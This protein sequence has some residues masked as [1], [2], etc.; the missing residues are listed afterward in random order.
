MK[1]KNTFILCA[2]CLCLLS[3]CG[4]GGSSSTADSAPEP[5][6]PVELTAEEPAPAEPADGYD[7]LGGSWEVGGTV[8]KNKL[9]DVRAEASLQNMYDGILL[10]FDEDG[11]FIRVNNVLV[12]TGSYIRLSEDSFLLKSERKYR[13]AFEDGKLAEKDVKT[14]GIANHIVSVQDWNGEKCLYFNEY[15]AI[16]GK[17]KANDDPLIF[18]QSIGNISDVFEIVSDFAPSASSSGASSSMAP[19]SSS[20]SQFTVS[21]GEKNA[22]ST[23]M[24]YLVYTAFSYSGLVEQLKYEGYTD[25]EAKY[26]ADN[27]GE[28]WY[29]QA[30][31]MAKQ[32]LNYTSLSKQK[33]I[34]QLEYEGFTS[35]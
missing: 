6:E 5:A 18:V 28:D 7:Q 8:Y 15:D 14:E 34:E 26:G 19:S 13:M 21:S 23:A 33:L 32:Y 17:A 12:T 11:S 16:T 4:K 25:R 20:S 30:V 9:I 27:C 35:D 1:G 29:E 22:L 2:L 3:A 24:D 10:G 31:K